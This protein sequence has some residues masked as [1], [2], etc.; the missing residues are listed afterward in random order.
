MKNNL[1][2]AQ[3]WLLKTVAEKT[4]YTDFIIQSAHQTS[5]NAFSFNVNYNW[6][7]NAWT[8]N[9]SRT[10]HVVWIEERSVFATADLL[11]GGVE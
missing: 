8:K 3:E 2:S 7:L 5:E 1:E 10:I 9:V 11:L 4:T 6:Q